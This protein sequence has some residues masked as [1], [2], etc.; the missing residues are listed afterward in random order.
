MPRPVL[1]LLL[2]LLASGPA[3]AQEAALRFE[4]ITEADGLS[5]LRIKA[6]GQDPQGFL[7]VGT[8]YG[9]NR[10]DGYTF[11]T[12]EHQPFD[13]TALAGSWVED[14][15]IDRRGGIW[16]SVVV[17]GVSRYNPTTESFHHFAPN[18]GDPHSIAD[19]SASAM[20]EDRNGHIWIGTHGAGL[21]R[22]DYETG[23]FATFRA[24]RR[25]PGSLSHGH[26]RELLEDRHGL[27]WVGT[28]DG[29]HRFDARTQQFIRYQPAEPEGSLQ[30]GYI[31]ALLEDASGTLW[32]GTADGLHRYDRA[33]DRFVVYQHDPLDPASLRD[34]RIET[35]YEAPSRPGFLW[36]V[37]AEGGL[38]RLDTRTDRFRH[39]P[40]D[41]TDEEERS[42]SSLYRSNVRFLYEDRQRTLWIGTGTGLYQFD[43]QT[44]TFDASFYWAWNPT[45]LP[46][47]SIRTIFED[48]SGML[49]IGT[50]SGLA[51]YNPRQERFR[52]EFDKPWF[53]NQTRDNAVQTGFVEADGTRWVGTAGSGLLRT[54]PDGQQTVYTTETTPPLVDDY[55]SVVLPSQQVP[56]VVWVGTSRGLTRLDRHT[57]TH[58]RHAPD[59]AETLAHPAIRSMAETPDG[60]LWI[61]LP[62]RGLNR[63]DPATGRVHRY[64]CNTEPPAGIGNCDV[65]AL[66]VDRAGVLWVGTIVDGIYRYEP[67]RDGFTYFAPTEEQPGARS[68]FAFL[69]DSRGLFWVGSYS[70]G[71]IR[72]DREREVFD[73][74]YT[75]RDGLPSN[76]V[77][78]ILEA[79]DGCL[80]LS[81]NRGLAKFDP[82]AETF[83]Q[84]DVDDGLQND[85]FGEKAAWRG[86]DGA[87]YFG[88]LDGLTW[89]DPEAVTPSDYVPPVVLTQFEVQGRSRQPVAIP[90]I[91]RR[92]AL[93]L[94]HDQNYLSFSFAALD[95]SNPK[96]NRYA[97]R[98]EGLDED[99]V[100]AGT[101]RYASY[102]NLP[103]RAYTLRVRGTN[104]DGVWN[105][106]G[107][108]LALTITPPFWRTGWF[109]VL[110]VLGLVTL[111]WSAHAGRVRAA[112]RRTRELE[113][114]RAAEREQVRKK[115]AKDFHDELGHLVTK[116]SLFGEILKRQPPDAEARTGYLDRII[117]TA[118]SLSGGM[119]D[120][121]WT[122]DPEPNTLH[123]TAVRLKDFGDA[124]YDKTGIAFRLRGLT[125][126]LHTVSLH[127][128]ARRH[129]TLL[130]KEAMHNVL[131]HAQAQNVTLTFAQ[132][133]GTL[134]VTL[135]DDGAGF[136]PEAI[137]RGRG[138]AN[139]HSRADRL[140]GTLA[141]TTIPTEG[142]QVQLSAPLAAMQES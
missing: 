53:R 95:Y 117:T 114:V 42:R 15:L 54:D 8:E 74:Y 129:L 96:K 105:P 61:G 86:P 60:K 11:Q 46:S 142:T 45:S 49:W 97:Y 20:L 104:G 33:H 102:T 79:D 78:Q 16:V 24:N 98:L 134:Y 52:H 111:A 40:A 58:Y 122:L 38:H 125:D 106:E 17:A 83:R 75:V 141:L 109:Y 108:A 56:G 27:L 35:L 48:D 41:P 47:H 136:D 101:R 92:T 23:R 68:T 6:I 80:W 77:K 7:W 72:F 121:L 116:I 82:L 32:V 130:F 139:M 124:L 71:L 137:R 126:D 62:Q 22:Y 112:R 65:S 81:T 36:V 66:Y 14:F 84:Y 19:G 85:E 119:G 31:T 64:P 44:E 90:G 120:F 69:E 67:E 115:A 94:P 30:N 55:V 100:E 138:L 135:A 21:S 107:V 76:W 10:Y 123:D 113:R 57:S 131:K 89:F 118:K 37:T 9:L 59:D 128:D 2:L 25:D 26:V 50:P 5:D 87:L 34:H 51:K 127:L 12:Y 4:R 29:L 132:A 140:G 103:P 1:S 73:R 133:A 3:V 99:W 91:A 63:L 43:W 70:D 88:G 39:Y 13:T 18:P 93:T 28:A 110:V